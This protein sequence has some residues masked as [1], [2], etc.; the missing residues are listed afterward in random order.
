[1]KKSTIVASLILTSSLTYA[2][3]LG[4]IAKGVLDNVVN[5]N[6]TET[7]NTSTNTNSNLSDSTVTSGLKCSQ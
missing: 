6:S 2:F 7:T 4:S 3:D 1:M 5:T